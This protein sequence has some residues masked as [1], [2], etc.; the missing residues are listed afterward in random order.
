MLYD[1]T[2]ASQTYELYGPKQYSTADIAEM[3]DK[4][5]FKKRRHINVPR[6]ILEPAA[7]ILNKLLW[8]PMLSA[9]QIQMEHIDQVIDEKAKTFKDLGIEPGEIS[10][11]TYQYVVSWIFLGESEEHDMTDCFTA[12]VPKRCILRSTTGEREGEEGRK[13]VLAR[14]RRPIEKE[15]PSLGQGNARWSTVNISLDVL[16]SSIAKKMRKITNQ[17]QG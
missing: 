8:W 7:R 17:L 4:E 11:F 6:Q 1:D 14:Y 16:A 9:E 10:K 12:R 15:R 3:V 2:T 5:I 13:E